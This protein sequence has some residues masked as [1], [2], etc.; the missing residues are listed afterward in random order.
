[1]IKATAVQLPALVQQA[2]AQHAD[3]IFIDTAG[4]SDV[5]AHHALQVA[6]LIL[7]PCRP[8]AADLDALEDTIHLIHLSK[9]KRAAVIL[10]AA[11]AR[12]R[13]A[14]DARAAIAERLT[15]APWSSASDPLMRPPGSTG[16]AS[17]N[18]NRTARLL[19]KSGLFIA[20]L[21]SSNHLIPIFRY[22]GININIKV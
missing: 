10:N 7:V 21:S 20:G 11:P 1:M 19:P 2:Q 13:M 12:G 15:V 5:A 8:S 14:D 6:D 17:R 18:T 16:A 22:K 9:D 3:L 4:R